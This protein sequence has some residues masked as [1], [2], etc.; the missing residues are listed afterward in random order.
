MRNHLLLSTAAIAISVAISG[1]VSA[2]DMA[3]KAPPVPYVT[4]FS[5]AGF[6]VGGNIGYGQSRFDFSSCPTICQHKG[7][8]PVGGLQGGYNWQAGRIVWGVE[9][10]VSAANFETGDGDYVRANVDL[11]A[12]IRGRLGIAFDRVLVYA[13]GGG[14]YVHAKGAGST[15]PLTWRHAD[16]FR[17]VVGGGIEYA[18]T[19]TFT[20]RGEAL[21]YLGKQSFLASTDDTATVKDIWIARI[22]VNHKF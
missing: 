20:V 17:P 7:S 3:L 5:W 15:T 22:G 18:L 19:N 14:G 12:S 10:D 9:G 4:P 8:G 21:G 13:T 6:Y 2:A 1:P 16:L 11:L